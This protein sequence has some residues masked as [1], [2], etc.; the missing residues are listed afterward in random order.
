MGKVVGVP[1]GERSVPTLS[2]VS[3]RVIFDPIFNV[4]VLTFWELHCKFFVQRLTMKE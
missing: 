1:V 4:L 3:I 2:D